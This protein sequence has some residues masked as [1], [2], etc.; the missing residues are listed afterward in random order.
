MR[1]VQIIYKKK[2]LAKLFF[3]Y[4]HFNTTI[5]NYIIFFTYVLHIHFQSD[6]FNNSKWICRF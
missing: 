6:P 3:H 2:I 1:N 5:E 4:I